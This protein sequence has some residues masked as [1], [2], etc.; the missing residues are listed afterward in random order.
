MD[1]AKGGD[2][3]VSRKLENSKQSSAAGSSARG[4]FELLE[5]DLPADSGVD[6]LG[7]NSGGA[8]LIC[9][10]NAGTLEPVLAV[11]DK[12][13]LANGRCDDGNAMCPGSLEQGS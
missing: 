3:V 9:G 12:D 4:E 5:V 7:L 10:M 11:I 8:K 2:G 13:T 6:A 1:E